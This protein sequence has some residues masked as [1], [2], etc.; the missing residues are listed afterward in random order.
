MTNVQILCRNMGNTT[1]AGTIMAAGLL[2]IVM[3]RHH[4][5]LAETALP[6]RIV[7]GSEWRKLSGVTAYEASVPLLYE[8]AW[9]TAQPAQ[10]IPKLATSLCPDDVFCGVASQLDKAFESFE[11]QAL[12]Y[13]KIA[14]E[15]DFLNSVEVSESPKNESSRHKRGIELI[16]D[17]FSWCC[18]V[19][20]KSQLQPLEE[21]QLTVAQ[22]MSYI[23]TLVSRDHAALMDKS[24][25]INIYTR[26]VEKAFGE[27]QKHVK[28]VE[29]VM[30]QFVN[31][32]QFRFNNFSGEMYGVFGAGINNVR[33]SLLLLYNMR[34]RAVS[35]RD[36]SRLDSAVH[37]RHTYRRSASLRL[38]PQRLRRK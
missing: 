14:H 2:W 30:S 11:G 31:S 13:G 16:G 29:T 24:E 37:R 35:R 4:G 32:M 12:E 23:K 36:F 9:L 33:N 8:T 25:S 28:S 7:S 38:R 6:V 26:G 27:V 18:D 1:V 22:Q 21:E 20:T 15:F 5:V 34:P 19:A 10:T 17:I 3:A